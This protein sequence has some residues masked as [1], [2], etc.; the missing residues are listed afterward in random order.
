MPASGVPRALPLIAGEISEHGVSKGEALLRICRYLGADPDGCI[1]FGDYAND[2]PM[3]RYAGLSFAMENAAPS[4][5]A[6]ADYV[7]PSNAEDGVAQVL[8]TLFG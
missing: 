2:I 5:Q 8:E 4:V 1:A 7:A 6:A 3:L